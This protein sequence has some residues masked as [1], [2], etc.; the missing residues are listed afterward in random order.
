MTDVQPVPKQRLQNL[1]LMDSTNLMK[2]P[3]M[4]ELP[5]KRG[6]KLMEKREKKKNSCPLSNPH[7]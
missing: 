1:E 3:K 5:D 6:F 2:F 4:T 7:S